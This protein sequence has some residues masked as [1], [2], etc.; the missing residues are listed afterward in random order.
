M[1][2]RN[3]NNN[4]TDRILRLLAEMD[5]LSAAYNDLS[6]RAAEYNIPLDGIM[7]KPTMLEFHLE[8]QRQ[9][10]TYLRTRPNVVRARER[11]RRMRDMD[12]LTDEAGVTRQRERKRHEIPRRRVNQVMVDSPDWK[13][14]EID[15]ELAKQLE[16]DNKLIEETKASKQKLIEDTIKMTRTGEPVIMPKHIA[17]GNDYKPPKPSD[18][19][20]RTKPKAEE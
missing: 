7:P 2:A 10:N 9:G 19:F 8:M 4:P 3:P 17:P 12:I 11:M 5:E 18:L 14:P 20:S 13:M 6:E 1:P 16:E 15:D